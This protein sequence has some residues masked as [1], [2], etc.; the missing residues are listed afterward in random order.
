M[1]GNTPFY[2]EPNPPIQVA[3]TSTI[4]GFCALNEYWFLILGVKC[5]ALL[6]S[7]EIFFCRRGSMQR[8]NGLKLIPVNSG[9]M[10]L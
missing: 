6:N 4:F 10:F 5:N 3:G 1:L 8:Y 9:S 7:K 2:T